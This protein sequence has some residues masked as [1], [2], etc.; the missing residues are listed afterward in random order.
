MFRVLATGIPITRREEVRWTGV[1]GENVPATNYGVLL[2]YVL[3]GPPFEEQLSSGLYTL[4]NV[5]CKGCNSYLGWKYV[6]AEEV[7]LDRQGTYMLADSGL[8]ERIPLGAPPIEPAALP[9]PGSPRGSMGPI[10]HSQS[11]EGGFTSSPVLTH[12]P[13]QSR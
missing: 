8:E 10:I 9:R 3:S 13:R 11:R 6:L 12:R 7:N 4:A 5:V 1:M 2:N